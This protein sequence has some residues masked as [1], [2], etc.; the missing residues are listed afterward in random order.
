[1]SRRG[2]SVWRRQGCLLFCSLACAEQ[3][4]TET[5]AKCLT[6]FTL[7]CLEPDLKRGARVR[8]LG[9]GICH[10][11]AQPCAAAFC[12]RHRR[13]KG[14]YPELLK[15][16]EMS[17]RRARVSLRRLLLRGAGQELP[18]GG[19]WMPWCFSGLRCACGR[20]ATSPSVFLPVLVSLLLPLSLPEALQVFAQVWQCTQMMSGRNSKDREIPLC[21]RNQASGDLSWRLTGWF[22][23]FCFS[24]H[25]SQFPEPE[26]IALQVCATWG[27]RNN[28]SILNSSLYFGRTVIIPLVLRLILLRKYLGL[29]GFLSSFPCSG[30]RFRKA[31]FWR[32]FSVCTHHVKSTG[33]ELQSEACE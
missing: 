4:C 13:E 26:R 20:V 23:S 19:W 33:A 17:W 5:F 9:A 12:S 7:C 30:L 27:R 8:R 15:K 2:A 24:C 10:P 29:N 31:L 32:R 25:E 3:T 6:F 1:M 18:A 11:I 28:K 22:F 16:T 14:K 21:G